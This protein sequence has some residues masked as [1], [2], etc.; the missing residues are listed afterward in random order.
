[1]RIASSIAGHSLCLHHLEIRSTSGSP[2]GSTSSSNLRLWTEM[3]RL[4]FAQRIGQQSGLRWRFARVFAQHTVRSGLF[5]SLRTLWELVEHRF[6]V[7][8]FALLSDRC[9]DK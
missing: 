5:Q 3:Y 6:L 9:M 4:G 2:S 7:H 1:M 8:G